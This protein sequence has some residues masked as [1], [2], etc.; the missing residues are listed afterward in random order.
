MN[1]GSPAVTV[2]DSAFIDTVER[3]AFDFFRAQTAGWIAGHFVDSIWDRTVLQVAHA[4]PAVR[5]A[6][7]AVSAMHEK[8]FSHPNYNR[9]AADHSGQHFAVSQYAKALQGFRR[10]LYL[11]ETSVDVVLVGA[12]LCVHFESLQ[13]RFVPALMHAENAMTLLRH[14]SNLSNRELD[15]GLLSAY[16]HLDF[17][18]SAFIGMR[19]PALISLLP[20][21]TELPQEVRSVT[22]ARRLCITWASRL[23]HF[24]RT[25]ADRFKYV[26]P[27]FVPLEVLDASIKMEESFGIIRILLRDFAQQPG[28]KLSFREQCGLALLRAQAAEYRIVAAGCLYSE[29]CIYDR[30]LPYFEEIY[31]ICRF[32]FDS[33]DPSCRILSASTD[34]SLLRSLWFIATHCRDSKVRHSA[35]KLLKAV[36]MDGQVWHVNAMIKSA[37]L[38]IQREEELCQV[39]SPSCE[40]VPEWRRVHSSGF[41][42][43]VLGAAN[44]EVFTARLRRRMNGMDGEWDEVV[45]SIRW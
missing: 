33:G 43:W 41:D 9:C 1:S 7:N 32:V 34:N 21:N 8:R 11:K 24:M 27:G 30:Y 12:L 4:E 18:G 29:E 19:V 5:H 22:H 44:K 13:E 15:P 23:L 14:Q 31:A 2:T 16:Q 42:E 35:L 26:S 36:P 45:E 10:L 38:C 40:D 37:E 6:V 3:R 28:I 25:V 39:P 20:T 17:Q